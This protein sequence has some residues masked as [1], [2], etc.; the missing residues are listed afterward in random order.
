VSRRRCLRSPA[1]RNGYQL[2]GGKN[3]VRDLWS[4]GIAKPAMGFVYER[5]DR[6]RGYSHGAR[7]PDPIRR[8][9]CAPEW[10][11]HSESAAFSKRALHAHIS[12]MKLDQ[13]L[14]HG[15]S[16]SAPL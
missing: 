7:S 1:G 14:H 10:Q 9:V 3:L 5:R 15:Q 6:S 2:V 4:I 12:A 8:Q 16:D 11:A 13:F